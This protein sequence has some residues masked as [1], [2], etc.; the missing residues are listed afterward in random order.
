MRML[1]IG[2][3]PGRFICDAHH[4]AWRLDG[5]IELVGGCF[6]SDPE[7]NRQAAERLGVDSARVSDSWQS[8]IAREAALPPARRAHFVAS[9]T[10]N[11]LHA[12]VAV[13]AMRHGFPVLSDKPLCYSL[14]EAEELERV[15]AETG[16]PFAL[17]HNY[18]GYAMVK[19]ARE[20]ISSGRLGR[21]L[22]AVVEY[23]QGGVA[24][25]MAQGRADALR[26]PGKRTERSACFSDIGVH[27][28][29]LLEYVSGIVIQQVCADC[30]TIVPGRELEDDASVLLRLSGGA[31]GVLLASQIAS[32]EEN[33]LSLR[34]WCEHGGLEW[35]QM[36]P[37]SLM[38]KWRDR[39]MEIRRSGRYF[40]EELP[41]TRAATRLP[42][43][44]PEGYLEAFATIYA[45]FAR[46]LRARA[47]GRQPQPEDL[48]V[49]GLAD[50]MRGM[51]IT[52]AVV[53][54]AAVESRWMAV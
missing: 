43:G 27:A 7:R 24:A 52:A 8:A 4:M 5:E 1:M 6:S 31:K 9:I 54:S 20:L 13:H 53:D 35:R 45:R 3:C 29:Q 36:E 38:V 39:P 14:A 19:Q 12:P 33:P 25:G 21:V 22:K 50:G 28:A 16:L 17:T 48:D 34:V 2:G 15:Q 37:N 40:D 51:R 49:P 23:P 26:D 46:Q 18:S 44:H 30:T 32:G 41:A 10:P 11:R 47:E 42:A